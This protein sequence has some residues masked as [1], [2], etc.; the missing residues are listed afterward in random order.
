MAHCAW[1]K[2]TAERF[3]QE[4]LKT[5]KAILTENGISLRPSY[6][7]DEKVVVD[8]HNPR[9]AQEIVTELVRVLEELLSEVKTK[10]EA[11][12]ERKRDTLD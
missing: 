12:R 7:D 3:V 1:T 10:V 9:R 8:R 6:D 4:V 5:G 2:E 11:S